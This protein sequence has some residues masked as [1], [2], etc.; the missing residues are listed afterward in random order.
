MTHPNLL[1]KTFPSQATDATPQAGKRKGSEIDVLVCPPLANP[2][3]YRY[4]LWCLPV[5]ANSRY[6]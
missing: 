2:I 3:R 4:V 1:G 5:I 6:S